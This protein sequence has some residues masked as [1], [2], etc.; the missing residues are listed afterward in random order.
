MLFIAIDDMRP[1]IGAMGAPV[2]TP[3]MDKLASESLM[4]DRAFANF[5]WCNPSRN[6]LLSGRRPDTNKVWNFNVDLRTTF[7]NRH[8]GGPKGTN[9][10]Y[11]TLPQHF[12]LHGYYT[13]SAGK[14]F[15]SYN[16][17]GA[18]MPINGD[19]PF[20]WSVPP[21]DHGKN[22][23]DNSSTCRGG[24][25]T[26]PGEYTGSCTWCN[27]DLHSGGG[28]K[29]NTYY[30]DTAI[31]TDAIG[32]L[33]LATASNQTRPWFVAAGFRDPHLPWRYPGKFGDHYPAVVQHTNHSEIPQ[34]PLAPMAWQYP[35]Y[36]NGNYGNY[37]KLDSEEN[38]QLSKEEVAIGTRAYFATITFTDSE[39]G[40]LLDAAR[41]AHSVNSKC[42]AA[43]CIVACCSLASSCTPSLNTMGAVAALGQKTWD[44]MVVVLWSDHGQN[45]GEHG[46]WCKMAAWEHSLRVAMMI[47]PA[48]TYPGSRSVTDSL[49][50]S[51]ANL[52]FNGRQRIVNLPVWIAECCI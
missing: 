4:F 35:V 24:G 52:D 2:Q 26:Y 17:I 42:R 29:N 31:A 3:A 28:A 38:M 33:A 6:S 5:P 51:L 7:D 8:P 46:T 14:I 13:T 30:A 34:D 49:L 19:Y 37:W 43:S 32:R 20:S 12:K 50:R 1:S 25:P 45:V 15:H 44:E 40:R 23:C 41:G 27:G 48:A 9:T 21:T 47:K 22:G 18:G 11:V 36:F 39:I 10:S 16:R